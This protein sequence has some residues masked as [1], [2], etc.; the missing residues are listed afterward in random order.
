MDGIWGSIV[1]ILLCFDII[2]IFEIDR[3]KWAPNA[4]SCF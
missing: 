4:N 3:L 1:V 2:E